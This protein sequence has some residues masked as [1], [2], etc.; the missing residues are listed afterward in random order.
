MAYTVPQLQALADQYAGQYGVPTNLFRAVIQNE[1][2]WNPYAQGPPIPSLGGQTA[3]GIAQFI[4][5][6]AQQYGVNVWDPTSSLSGSARYLRD[7][8]NRTGSW[9]QALVCY[10]G[11]RYCNNPNP[12]YQPYPGRQNIQDA[13][14]NPQYAGGQSPSVT[15]DPSTGLP[16]AASPGGGTTLSA[17]AEKA[18][19]KIASD[20][21]VLVGAARPSSSNDPNDPAAQSGCTNWITTPFACLVNGITIL[22]VVV[23]GIII[24][25]IGTYAATKET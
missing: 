22:G 14:R 2:S 10:S 13:L 8:Y 24:I 17:S 4:P 5:G 16:V 25:G 12:D 11:S 15:V 1:S 18:I 9:T 19:S 21:D 20:L 7:L 23:L 6:T 3:Q